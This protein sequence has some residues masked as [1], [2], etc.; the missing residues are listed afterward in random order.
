VTPPDGAPV[1]VPQPSWV[2][3]AP[4]DFAPGIDSIVT[5]YDIALQC[6]S[7]RGPSR[8]NRDLH[9]PSTSGR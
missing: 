3:V 1:M 8:P 7:T 5:L 6:A 2:V 9:S 4:P